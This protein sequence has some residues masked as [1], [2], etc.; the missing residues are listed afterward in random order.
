[1]KGS[2]RSAMWISRTGVQERIDFSPR[3]NSRPWSLRWV[4]D[5]GSGLR[6]TERQH[7]H[8]R[9]PSRIKSSRI[10]SSRVDAGSGAQRLLGCPAQPLN[11][12]NGKVAQMRDPADLDALVDDPPKCVSEAAA[13]YGA[14]WPIVH[15]AFIEHVR[16]PLAAVTCS[17]GVGYG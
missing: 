10:K 15:A 7:S 13:H 5:P 17:E 16:V 14:S 2:K 3:P 9:R 12:T 6:V 11:L 1:M 8:M 4:R